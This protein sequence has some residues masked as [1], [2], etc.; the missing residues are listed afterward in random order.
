MREYSIIV[1]VLT[2]VHAFVPRI[3]NRVEISCRNTGHD[4]VGV[5]TRAHTNNVARFDSLFLQP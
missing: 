2:Q 5:I 3:E 4:G 1:E